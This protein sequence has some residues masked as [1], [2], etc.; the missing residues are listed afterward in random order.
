MGDIPWN[1]S[2]D[3]M[4]KLYPELKTEDRAEAAESLS[5]YFKVKGKIYDHLGDEGKLKDTLLRIQ[6]EKRSGN[7]TASQSDIEETD[8][9]PRPND[10]FVHHLFP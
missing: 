4:A 9:T 3:D 8:D 5:R 10:R 7:N 1:L 6:C 2:E